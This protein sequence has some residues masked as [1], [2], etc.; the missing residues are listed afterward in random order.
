MFLTSLE[1]PSLTSS[2]VLNVSVSFVLDV[3]ELLFVPIAIGRDLLSTTC[4][5]L[6]EVCKL[7]LGS[8][9]IALA[10]FILIRLPLKKAT[11]KAS[12]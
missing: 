10:S 2:V 7:L 12:G 9:S 5:L 4:A 1:I 6:S 8:F 3:C 11:T